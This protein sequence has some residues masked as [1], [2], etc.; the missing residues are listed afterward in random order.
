MCLW[1]ANVLRPVTQGSAQG[2]HR[3]MQ[4]ELAPQTLPPGPEVARTFQK[5]NLP[6]RLCMHTHS[7]PA[8]PC[9]STW[10]TEEVSGLC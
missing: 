3:F 4:Y 5:S 10:D 8:T 9:L 6:L 2:R 7:L 1:G